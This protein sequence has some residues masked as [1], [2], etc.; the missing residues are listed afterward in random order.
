VY[1][2]SGVPRTS[3]KPWFRLGVFHEIE[4]RA[5]LNHAVDETLIPLEMDVVVAGYIGPPIFAG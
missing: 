2:G 3:V 4:L 5:K 1:T